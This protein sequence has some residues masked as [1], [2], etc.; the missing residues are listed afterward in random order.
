MRTGDSVLLD[1][2]ALVRDALVL[3]LP[4]AARCS[5]EC[6][7][8]CPGCGAD[9]RVEPCRCASENDVIDPRLARLA[10][11]RGRRSESGAAS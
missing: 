5:T 9:L 7:G 1:V 11:W 4:M 3:A 6:R 8:L 2:E 10:A